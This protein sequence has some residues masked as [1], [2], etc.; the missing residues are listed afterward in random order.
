MPLSND[1]ARLVR[2]IDELADAIAIGLRSSRGLPARERQSARAEI[3]RCVLRLD[4]LR[5]RLGEE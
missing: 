1:I 2:T 5:T 4:E 3:E